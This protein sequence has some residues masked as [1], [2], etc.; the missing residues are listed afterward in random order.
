[1]LSRLLPLLL[2]ALGAVF[3]LFTPTQLTGTPLFVAAP[4]MAAPL[5]TRWQTVGFG[6]LALAAAVLLHLV[7]G[8]VWES[9][10]TQHLAT[11]LAT[12][13]FATAIAVLLNTVV[14]RGREQLASARE[15]AEAAQR[16]V[17]PTP[18]DRIAGLRVAARY[19]AAQRDALI[20]G[21][22][23]GAQDTP[24]GVRM[25]MGDVRGKGITAIETVAVV[26]G[27]FREAA[28]QQETLADVARRL[29]HALARESAGRT[30][31]DAGEAFVTCVLVEIPPGRQTVR[32]LNRGHPPPLL[33]DGGGRVTAL[34]P[35]AF[36][37]PLGL[38]DLDPVPHEPD[39]WPFP[40]DATLLLYT[41]GL[42]EARDA[43]GTFYDPVDRLRG[44][45]FPTPTRL[46]N[47]LADDVRHF[48]GDLTDDD[49]ALLA[50]HKPGPRPV[51]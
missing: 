28:D 9:V 38:S 5:F 32:T 6:C 13:A 26:L 30:A 10:A 7:A 43:A 37:L 17:V 42:S 29:E 39:S 15:V 1:M 24:Y 47:T 31:A 40:A 3:Q 48:S 4:L 21:D 16:A 50:A 36:Q 23:Y 14:D 34:T 27:A 35:R 22:L 19:E 18:A 8:S 12:I 2:I 49:M 20:G 44:R 41:D 25:L 11:E 46:L 45:T 51:H 33:L